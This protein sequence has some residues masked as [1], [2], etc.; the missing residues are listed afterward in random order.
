MGYEKSALRMKKASFSEAEAFLAVADHHGFGAAARE[1]GVTQS[2]I[3]RRIAGLESRIG[4]RLIERTTRRVALTEAGVSYASELRDVLLRLE[5]A[6]AHVQN[7]TAEPEGLLRVT[8]PTAF[9]RA[10]VLPCLVRLADRYAGLRF[11][12]DLS[13]R[14]VDLL[15]GNIDVAIRLATSPQSGIDTR[16]IGSFAL[17]L[18]ASPSYVAEHGLAASP[19]DISSHRCIAL[20]T[21]APRIAW[22]LA[23]QGRTV[24]IELSPR[25]IVSDLTALHS[26]VLAG[27]GIAVLPSYL[28]ASDMK[29]GRL[30]DAL[31]GLGLPDVDV[32]TAYPRDRGRLRKVAVLLDELGRIHRSDP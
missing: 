26:L 23:W 12:L 15:D 11:E 27:A 5:N 10:C 29:A 14:Y 25:M 7:R 2:T 30:V 4:L 16:R 28:V 9:G 24:D 8:M 13:D 20:R 31:P 18:C 32:F 19:A 3:S 17:H 21:Y 22:Q 6:D 1:L